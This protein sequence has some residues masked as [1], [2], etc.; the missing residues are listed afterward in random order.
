M[1][2]QRN[3]RFRVTKVEKKGSR[4]YIDIEVIGQI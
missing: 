1:L 4:Y 2:I 3:T